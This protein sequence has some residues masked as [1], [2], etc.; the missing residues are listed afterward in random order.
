MSGE[1]VTKHNAAKE[2][3]VATFEKMLTEKPI[4]GVVNLQ[5]LPCQQLSNMRKQL[6]KYGVEIVMAKKRLMKLAIEKVK[7]TKKDLEQ[8]EGHMKGMPA[9]LFTEENPFTL[10]KIIK[11]NKSKAP[12]KAGQEAP[13]D[14]SVSAGPTN[15]LPGPII[16]ELAGFGI[17]TKVDNGKLT[18]TDD[19][20]VAKEGDVIDD[21]LA[22]LLM[23]LG[24]EPMEIGLDLIAI[25]ENGT[26]FTKN[27]LDIDEEAFAADLDN[28]ARWAFN[29][30]V[31][32]VYPVKENIGVFITKAFT[33]T[34][35]L[36]T[37]A[38]II[39]SETVKDMI[40]KAHSQMLNVKNTAGIND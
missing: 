1:Y 39:C 10:F 6:R 26:V 11:K 22:S 29:L 19:A 30:S 21:K 27:V 4:I 32:A 33:E 38:N 23:R 2:K 40:G 3:T 28:C 5:S 34:K 7:G 24:I 37:E 25:Y 14:I 12:A 35:G 8:L 16:S 36:A 9:I 17:K 18:I 13:S 15:F 31:E 20:I